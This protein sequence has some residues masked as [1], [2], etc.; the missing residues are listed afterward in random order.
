MEQKINVGKWLAVAKSGDRSPSF[1]RWM[2][3]SSFPTWQQNIAKPFG[4]RCGGRLGLEAEFV[5]KQL[6]THQIFQVAGRRVVWRAGGCGRGVTS[7]FGH[8]GSFAF[9]FWCLDLPVWTT[10]WPAWWD[11]PSL[12][13]YV[14][15]IY[16]CRYGY[17]FLVL[18]LYF[19]YLSDTWC[20]SDF[21]LQIFPCKQ[22]TL[23][24][25]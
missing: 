9:N 5:L 16:T 2:Q 17:I 13:T 24:T 7:I 21:W 11:S 20:S 19:P 18:Y 8:S 14:Y 6:F 10:S 4:R 1:F 3:Y 23:R 22:L 25:W 12:I 15:Y